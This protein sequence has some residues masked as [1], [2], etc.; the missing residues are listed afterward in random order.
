MKNS[1]DEKYLLILGR[2]LQLCKQV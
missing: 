1:L 2:M